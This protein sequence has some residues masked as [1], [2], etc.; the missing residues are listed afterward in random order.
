MNSQCEA[1][2]N[3]YGQLQDCPYTEQA[4]RKAEFDAALNAFADQEKVD[5]EDLRAFV[6]KKWFQLCQSEAKRKP[7]TITG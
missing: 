1:L 6:K 4:A 2:V 5:R 3:L 7:P